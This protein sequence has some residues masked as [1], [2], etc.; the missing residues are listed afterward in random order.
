[1]LRKGGIHTQESASTWKNEVIL[2]GGRERGRR[3][4]MERGREREGGSEG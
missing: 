1:M 4:G 2:N 3:E